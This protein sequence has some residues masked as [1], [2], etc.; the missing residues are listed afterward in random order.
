MPL[1]V[2]MALL[3][4]CGVEFIEPHPPQVELLDRGVQASLVDE[5]VVYGV[6]LDLSISDAEGCK[7]AQEQ[8]VMDA[9]RHFLAPGR[10][11][12]ELPV[13]DLSPGCR[14]RPDRRL[15]LAAL[16]ERLKLVRAAY[17]G[18]EVRPLYLYVNNVS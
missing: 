15:P 12:Q 5:P 13:V 4:G 6:L 9:R 14:P 2:L 7:A 1:V 18:H 16:D 3:V 8:I 11:G 10:V 17:A